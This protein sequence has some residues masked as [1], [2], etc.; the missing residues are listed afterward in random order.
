[1][2][3][4]VL[5]KVDLRH[6]VLENSMHVAPASNADDILTSLNSGYGDISNTAHINPTAD[7]EME[8]GN[9]EELRGVTETLTVNDDAN[10]PESVEELSKKKIHPLMMV[11]PW[12][13]GNGKFALTD[14]LNVCSEAVHRRVKKARIR[15]CILNGI[16]ELT[17]CVS[18]IFVSTEQ[19]IHPIWY[20]YTRSHPNNLGL[21]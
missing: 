10:R 12:I 9:L 3:I 4:K 8:D 16:H 15:R 21:K 14:I 7:G 11:D 5:I 17:T 20:R 19:P 18:S 6:T 2:S 1:M 13:V